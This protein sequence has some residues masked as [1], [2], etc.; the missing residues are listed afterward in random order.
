LAAALFIAMASPAMAQINPFRS[1]RFGPQLTQADT[2]ML[3]ASIDRLNKRKDIAVGSKES[4]RNPRTGSN[5]TTTVTAILDGSCHRLH[6][7]VFPRGHQPPGLYDLTWC[8]APD[9]TWKI[10]S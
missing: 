1:Q 2:N 9:G 5:G 6:H 3:F 7:E 10:K 4:W 8:P